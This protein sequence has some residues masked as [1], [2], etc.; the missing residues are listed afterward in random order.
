MVCRS[1]VGYV[2]YCIAC[3]ICSR[4]APDHGYDALAVVICE[5]TQQTDRH[6]AWASLRTR[7]LRG[8]GREFHEI[9]VGNKAHLISRMCVC[10]CAC[11]RA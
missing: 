4:A 3:C 5:M 10:V 2:V 9:S 8:R 7:S 6:H 1:T 11:V